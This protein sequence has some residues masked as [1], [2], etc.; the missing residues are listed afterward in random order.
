MYCP[1]VR[2]SIT[3]FMLIL[4]QLNVL[5]KMCDSAV[6]EVKLDNRIQLGLWTFF[7]LKFEELDWISPSVE[8]V[9]KAIKV[10]HC[11]RRRHCVILLHEIHYGRKIKIK[12]LIFVGKFASWVLNLRDQNKGGNC[13]KSS[14]SIN[15]TEEQLKL[16]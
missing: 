2:I 13:L 6:R 14:K 8:E 15:T 3:K 10:L 4:Q 9:L 11:S 16:I 12:Y 5:Y 7:F 1:S